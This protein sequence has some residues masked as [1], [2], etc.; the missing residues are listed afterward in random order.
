M[1]SKGCGRRSWAEWGECFACDDVNSQA[2]EKALKS[3]G[4]I[5]LAEQIGKN[6]KWGEGVEFVVRE[7]IRK[8]YKTYEDSV[9]I[10]IHEYMDDR[11]H[12]NLYKKT[13]K[14]YKY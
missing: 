13:I 2:P 10:K 12:H 3:R 5:F 7:Y 1:E 11:L 4:Q 9:Y 8:A 6:M 14:Q